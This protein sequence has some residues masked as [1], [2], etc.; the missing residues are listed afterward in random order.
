MY[1]PPLGIFGEN[2]TRT[3]AIE[4]APWTKPK[5]RMANLKCH[6]GRQFN[7]ARLYRA[8]QM[9]AWLIY[10]NQRHLRI[11][12]QCHFNNRHLLRNSICHANAP[13]QV[14]TG[15]KWETGTRLDTSFI[16]ILALFCQRK[17]FDWESE[18]CRHCSRLALVNQIIGRLLH[19]VNLLLRWP[20][21]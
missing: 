17:R 7:G 20:L 8:V 4:E 2:K 14:S 5:M 18:H 15:G 16:S 11:Y 19:A 10:L 9:S 3:K 6:E 1:F 12:S 13:V 21:F